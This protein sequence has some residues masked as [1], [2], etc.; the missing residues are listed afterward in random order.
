MNKKKFID[1]YLTCS[2]SP[3]CLGP[4][5]HAQPGFSLLVA[6]RQAPLQATTYALSNPVKQESLCRLNNHSQDAGW[7]P[8]V[9]LALATPPGLSH[10]LPGRYR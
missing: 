1:S 6:Q 4:W 9:G 2:L 3:L 10:H 8:L 5:P 7:L